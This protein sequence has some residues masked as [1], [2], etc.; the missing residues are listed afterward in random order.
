M[1]RE[2]VASINMCL[3]CTDATRWFATTKAPHNLPKFDALHEHHTSPLF[4]DTERAAL[5]FATEL[6]ERRS[7]SQ[8]T[9]AE[10]SRHYSEREICEL[11]WSVASEH[12]YNINNIGLNIGSDGLCA[13]G[14]GSG[15]AASGPIA[16]PHPRR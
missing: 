12:H 11:V 1:V 13:I 16:D 3:W 15:S 9:F 14:S 2:R 7:V 4:S 6:T 8:E 5:D 10:L